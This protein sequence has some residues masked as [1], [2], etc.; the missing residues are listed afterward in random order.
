MNMYLCESCETKFQAERKTFCPQCGGTDVKDLGDIAQKLTESQTENDPEQIWDILKELCLETST[1]PYNS[2]KWNQAINR[3]VE[4]L[5]P[6][7][8]LKELM[9][10]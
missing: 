1:E 10:A 3:T 8:N 6:H 9:K 5:I 4:R 7:L 2:A